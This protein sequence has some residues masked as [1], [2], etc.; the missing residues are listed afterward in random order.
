MVV[1]RC[2]KQ[3]NLNTRLVLSGYETST[4]AYQIL[5]VSIEALTGSVT[6]SVQRV[7]RTAYALKAVSLK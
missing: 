1:G 6:Y 5:K 2:N 4:P 7:S 3:R